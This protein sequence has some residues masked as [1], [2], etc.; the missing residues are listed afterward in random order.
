MGKNVKL[1]QIDKKHKNVSQN[2]YAE[3]QGDEAVKAEVERRK[4]R[5][6]R[7]STLYAHEGQLHPRPAENAAYGAQNGAMGAARNTL[8][9]LNMNTINS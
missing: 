2:P 7:G 6:Q 3:V 4:K 1:Q 5:S 8:P 9:S